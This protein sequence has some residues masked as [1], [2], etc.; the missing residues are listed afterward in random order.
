MQSFLRI[1]AGVLV[2]FGIFL[3]LITHDWHCNP[4]DFAGMETCLNNQRSLALS[5][6]M[7]QQDH[8]GR[9]PTK[10]NGLAA[11]YQASRKVYICPTEDR[12]HRGKVN[13]Y[14]FNAFLL[15]RTIP[16]NYPNADKTLLTADAVRPDILLYSM[17]DI[18]RTHH[19]KGM[20]FIASFLDGHVE[21]IKSDTIIELDPGKLSPR[22]SP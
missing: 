10:W 21:A 9:F 6:T 2:G 17:D 19:A 1:F 7:Y 15:G 13:G 3:L 8:D 18:N 20:E 4:P 11:F 5:I 12:E 22:R 16:D 14:G